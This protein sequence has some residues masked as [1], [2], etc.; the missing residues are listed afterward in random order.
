MV[1]GFQQQRAEQIDRIIGIGRG[2][3]H[4][5]LLQSCLCLLDK[6]IGDGNVR[7][8]SSQYGANQQGGFFPEFL[9]QRFGSLCHLFVALVI[10]IQLFNQTGFEQLRQ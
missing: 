4:P 6:W 9:H 2:E 10:A 3:S 8:Q 5:L 1:T 7:V